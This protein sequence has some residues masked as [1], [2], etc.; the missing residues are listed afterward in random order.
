M[1]HDQLMCYLLDHSLITKAQ[2]GFLAN[3][4]TGS[5][6][7]SCFNDL[8]LVSVK[9]EKLIDIIYLDFR[10]AFDSL[11]H[12]KVIAKLASYGVNIIMNYCHGFRLF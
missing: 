12:P 7:L 6:L 4:S 9:N 2:H 1:I 3:K 11:V 10:Q 5:N 8:H